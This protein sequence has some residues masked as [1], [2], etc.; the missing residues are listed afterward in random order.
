MALRLDDQADLE[1][2]C[3]DIQNLEARWFLSSSHVP[4]LQRNADA[5]RAFC[6]ERVAAG[7]PIAVRYLVTL[8]AIGQQP[9]LAVLESALMSGDKLL[10]MAA[11]CAGDIVGKKPFPALL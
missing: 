11:T 6:S 5:V 4:L 9:D 3:R 8:I 7:G 1:R 2:F 10:Y